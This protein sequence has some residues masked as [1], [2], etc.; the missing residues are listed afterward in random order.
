MTPK[1]NK[2]SKQLIQQFKEIVGTESCF[3]NYEI[4]WVYSFGGTI[5]ERDWIPDLILL[6]QSSLQISKILKLANR[7][8]IPVTPRGSGTSL[9]GG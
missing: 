7:N 8:S 5:F 6:P 4:R 1:Y 2:I 9:S 3:D